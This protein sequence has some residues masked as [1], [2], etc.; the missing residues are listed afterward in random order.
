MVTLAT[1]KLG[2]K[3]LTR[4]KS[5]EDS[6]STAQPVA[7]SPEKE[8]M[9]FSNYPHVEKIFQCIQKKL[10]KTSINAS[11]FVDSYKNSVLT[12]RMF[13]TS[14]MKAAIHLWARFLGECGHLEEHTI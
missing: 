10:G 3:D 14:S 9:K 5:E 1:R 2:Q 4:P 12:W 11:F 13:M 6:P 8:N 7:V